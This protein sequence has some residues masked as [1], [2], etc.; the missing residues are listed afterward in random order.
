[1]LLHDTGSVITWEMGRVYGPAFLL[2][3][4]SFSFILSLF[5]HFYG[6]QVSS[7]VDLAGGVMTVISRWRGAGAFNMENWDS[8]IG[9][10]YPRTAGR[11]KAQIPL[12]AGSSPERAQGAWL[13]GGKHDH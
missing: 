13:F 6:R 1:M 7:G 5:L 12:R 9:S 2:L 3:F 8:K 11:K 4:F 10:R